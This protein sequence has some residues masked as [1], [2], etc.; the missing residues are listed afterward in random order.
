[1]RRVGTLSLPPERKRKYAILFLLA[2][3]NDAL[4]ILEIFN[5]F[6]ELLLDIFTAAV[7]TYLLGELDP[8]V[9]LVAVLDAVPFVDLAPVW[10]GYIYYRY[11]KELQAITP[12]PKVEVFK[13]PKEGDYEE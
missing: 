4:D 2:A 10:T 6:I 9:F 11:Y 8:I 3:F 1:M 7:I 12:K 13:I 5:P